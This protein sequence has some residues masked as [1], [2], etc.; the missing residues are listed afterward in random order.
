M[1]AQSVDLVGC[2]ASNFAGSAFTRWLLPPLHDQTFGFND[3]QLADLCLWREFF[4]RPKRQFSLETVGLLRLGYPRLAQ[5]TNVPAVVAQNG[6]TLEEWR[7]LVQVTL[8]FHIRGSKS[9]A[10]PDDMLR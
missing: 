3:R 1:I 8:D 4:L 2:S 9:V 5:I 10:I 7:A 6:V